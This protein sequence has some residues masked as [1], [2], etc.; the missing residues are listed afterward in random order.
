MKAFTKGA[1]QKINPISP[2]MEYALELIINA[3]KLNLK[4]TETPIDLY[5]RK[6]ESKLRT[7][8]DGWR[9]LRFMLLYCPNY[10]F[11]IPG[12]AVFLIGFAG[13]SMLLKGPVN[14]LG[15][16]FDFHAMIFFSMLTLLGFQLINLGFF[17]KSYALTEGFERKNS[18]FLN[19]Y[20]I[21]NLEKGILLGSFLTLFGFFMSISILKKWFLFGPIAQERSELFALILI[22]IGIQIVFSSFLISLIGMKN[23]E[24]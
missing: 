8:R 15:H 17:A 6:G 3:S 11:I 22:I 12:G 19:F 20:K 13:M 10:L 14:F 2:G 24:L 1:Y 16:V 23:K 4:R 9:S 18:F 5:L 7:F 21:F